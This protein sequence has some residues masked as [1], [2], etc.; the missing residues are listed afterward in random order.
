MTHREPA[1]EE[2]AAILSGLRDLGHDVGSLAELRHSGKRYPAAISLL[3]DALVSARERATQM[4]IV[5]ALSVPWAKPAATRP[6][7]EFFRT[8]DDPSELGVRWAAGNALE[9]VWS[10]DAFED[11]ADL[12]RD[13]AY[14]RS[15]EMVVLGMA[16]SNRV[17]AG[18]ILIGL[19][20][21]PDVNGHAVKALRKLKIPAARPGLEKMLHDD[22]GW[23][24]KEAQRALTSLAE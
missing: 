2:E 14:G 22:R 23:V 4:E 20:E 6:L 17:E 10:D 15:R 5:R 3:V 19:L 21:D 13:R 8:V 7:I 12:A 9:V 11:L 16:K 18:E 1:A 24:R